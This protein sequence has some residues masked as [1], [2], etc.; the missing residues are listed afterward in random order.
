MLNGLLVCP[1][2]VLQARC[3]REDTK[4]SHQS[5]PN[6]PPDFLSECRR[7]HPADLFRNFIKWNS[8]SLRLGDYFQRRRNP[9]SVPNGYEMGSCKLRLLRHFR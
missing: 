5:G 6:G 2:C 9:G 1:L 4:T 8:G 7:K 3:P